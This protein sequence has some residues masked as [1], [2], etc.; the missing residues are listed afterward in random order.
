MTTGSE[1][2][3]A[4]TGTGAQ[5]TTPGTVKWF[6]SEKGYGLISQRDSTDLFV[7]FSEIDT[8]GCSLDARQAFDAVYDRQSR[9][10]TQTGTPLM[11]D[12]RRYDTDANLVTSIDSV[13]AYLRRIGRAALLS[14]A[15]ACPSST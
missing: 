11:P 14:A 4:P 2:A 5:D 9:E 10:P 13:R 15:A 1:C 7:H 12:D 6:N 3:I 8:S